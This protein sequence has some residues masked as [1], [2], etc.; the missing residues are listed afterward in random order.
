[1][2]YRLDG[3]SQQIRPESEAVEQL[4]LGL[5]ETPLPLEATLG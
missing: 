4:L 2:E 3:Q 5:P 1:V